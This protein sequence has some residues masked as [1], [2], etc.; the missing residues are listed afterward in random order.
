MA[1]MGYEAEAHHI[2]ELFL[3]GKRDEAIMAV[4]ASFAD[5]ISLIG[6]PARIADRLAAWREALVL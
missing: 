6:P 3:E 2:Q 1:R 5:E 4:P